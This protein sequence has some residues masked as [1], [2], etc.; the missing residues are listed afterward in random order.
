MQARGLG[1]VCLTPEQ[2]LYPYN[3][4]SENEELRRASVDYF[5]KNL[6]VAAELE[7]DKMLCTSGWGS[8][9][10]DTGPA[11]TRAITSLGELL[12]RAEKLGVTLAFEVLSTFESNLACNLAGTK[13]ILDAL[14][15]PSM[16]L[17]VD[18]V[19]VN[20]GGD[21]LQ[22]YFD[23]FGSRICHFHLTDGSPSGHVPLGLGNLPVL[24]YIKQLED[25]AYDGAITL[26]IGDTSWCDRPHE[27]TWTGFSFLCQT[28]E[29]L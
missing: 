10:Q 18:T 16:R 1:I 2:V 19:A 4:A 17:C 14:P 5:L 28:L 12:E 15:S 24:T 21:T 3:I 7:V 11:F 20:M 27:A 13:R 25:F 8:Y 22:E 6:E 29:K 9:G 26:E 23:T